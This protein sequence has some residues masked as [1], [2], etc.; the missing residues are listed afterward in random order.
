MDKKETPTPNGVVDYIKTSG[1]IKV[2]SIDVA[3]DARTV[4][5]DNSNTIMI[6]AKAIL[7]MA[8]QRGGVTGQVGGG[9]GVD[10]GALLAPYNTRIAKI[11]LANGATDGDTS[12]DH[13]VT[14]LINNGPQVRQNVEFGEHKTS[15]AIVK[16]QHEGYAA[17]FL[18]TG[19]AVTTTFN[20][21]DALRFT[22]AI[23][24]DQGNQTGTTLYNSFGLL[25]IENELFAGQWL[26]G[27]GNTTAYSSVVNVGG[28]AKFIV[29]D[30]ATTGIVVGDYL[31]VTGG[32]DIPSCK[33]T[34]VNGTGNNAITTNSSYTGG[35]VG[36]VTIQNK[37]INLE[38]DSTN[39][40][41]IV[42][43]IQF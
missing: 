29:H 10:D 15:Q 2:T 24:A 37:V 20:D 9:P 7:A 27:N 16:S 13:T 32:V 33:V 40:I 39:A 12:L 34:A 26:R 3:T 1:H 30:N 36:F 11:Q 42:W 19:G 35:G 21:I 22:I 23:A 41:E 31:T 38:K 5:Y 43:T 25:T 6:N 17:E 8:L 28:K 4:V 14:E 18:T